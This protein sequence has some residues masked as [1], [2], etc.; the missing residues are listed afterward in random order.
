MTK[1]YA[2]TNQKGGIGKT[3]TAQAIGCE[4]CRRGFKTLLIDIDQQGNLTY[5]MGESNETY[6]SAY[7][8]LKGTKTAKE[9][10][11]QVSEKLY[12]IPSSRLLAVIE[13]ELTSLVGREYKLK[14]ALAPIR[15]EYDFIIIDT[16]PSLG[17]P[18]MNAF[19]ASDGIIVPTTADAFSLIGFEMLKETIAAVKEYCNP[20]LT[21][22]G[23]LLIKFNERTNLNRAVLE[24]AKSNAEAIG[25]HVFETYIRE[26][27][28]VREAQM[29]RANIF[30]YAPQSNAAEDYKNAVS[31]I[32]TQEG[33]I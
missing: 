29:V 14:N 20:N 12:L 25:T 19:V 13:P 16:P 3:T 17:L 7:E 27:I 32:L 18:T 28:K 6:E 22:L 2:I 31:E 26:N 9:V 23:V 21:I 24:M 1:V 8:L 5:Q 4:L 10:I 30:D 33:I 15:D 11:K